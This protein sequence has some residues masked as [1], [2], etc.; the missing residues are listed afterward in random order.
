MNGI[1]ATGGVMA[2]GPDN[3]RVFFA[4]R[5][6]ATEVVVFGTVVVV[7]GRADNLALDDKISGYD[8]ERASLQLVP[9]N[10]Q[11]YHSLPIRGG[12]LIWQVYTAGLDYFVE[13][14]RAYERCG[15]TQ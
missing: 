6:E 10:L 3:L 2:V 1:M 14:D 13:G 7:R 12:E 4:I 15:C 9:S 5:R 11:K 8:V